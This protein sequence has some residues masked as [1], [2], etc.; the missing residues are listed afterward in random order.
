MENSEKNNLKKYFVQKPSSL[1]M[2]RVL[3]TTLFGLVLGVLSP[4][5]VM[6]SYYFIYRSYMT[7]DGFIRFI[8]FGGTLSARISLC[9]IIN[10]GIFFLFI[11]KE[12]YS[13]ARGIIIATFLYAGLI[14]YLKFFA[15][16]IG[17]MAE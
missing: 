3:D 17:M 10:L 16:P 13:S 14:V 2:K 7:L 6:L 8:C 11:W 9:V 15:P 5:L 1:Q 12:K 4:V